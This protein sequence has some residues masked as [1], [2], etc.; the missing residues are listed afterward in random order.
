MTSRPT[1]PPASRHRCRRRSGSGPAM[2]LS[3]AGVMT[4][5]VVTA[6]APATRVPEAPGC[7]RTCRS[8]AADAARVVAVALRAEL[9][10]HV[11]RAL[12]EVAL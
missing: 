12:L 10:S 2:L 4:A 9:A 7:V 11:G 6:N 8:E 1:S 5:V 3:L